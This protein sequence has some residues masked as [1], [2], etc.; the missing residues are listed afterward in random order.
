MKKAPQTPDARSLNRLAFN[1]GATCGQVKRHPEHEA[2]RTGAIRQ[3][4]VD[5]RFRDNNCEGSRGGHAH[6]LYA[7]GGGDHEQHV[8]WAGREQWH[9]RTSGLRQNARQNQGTTHVDEQDA[10]HSAQERHESGDE[11]LRHKLHISLA[12]AEQKRGGG[13]GRA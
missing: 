3:A 7:G 10:K 5:P 1:F 2:A 9:H 11:A 8:A 12:N 6:G 4:S 13:G